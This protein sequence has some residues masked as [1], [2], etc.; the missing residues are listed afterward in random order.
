MTLT[1]KEIVIVAL[2][3]CIAM[4]YAHN[5]AA[6]DE[7]SF[8]KLRPP[9][10]QIQLNGCFG[11]VGKKDGAFKLYVDSFTFLGD[12]TRK[13]SKPRAKLIRVLASARRI[14]DMETSKEISLKNILSG[15]RTSVIGIDTGWRGN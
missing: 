12:K 2:F 7:T 11:R 10:S 13:L 4:G 8:I 14:R 1:Q 15:R 9:S 3:G 6:S 5:R